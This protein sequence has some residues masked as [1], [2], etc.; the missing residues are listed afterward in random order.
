MGEVVSGTAPTLHPR[1]EQTDG[2][3][4]V[5]ITSS[6][7]DNRSMDIG[8]SAAKNPMNAAHASSEAETSSSADVQMVLFVGE[9]GEPWIRADVILPGIERI[10]DVDLDVSDT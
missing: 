8:P 2:I 4:S 5:V 3:K 6:T 10:G 1:S 7:P 9:S